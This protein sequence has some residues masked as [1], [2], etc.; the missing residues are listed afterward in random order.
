MAIEIT[1]LDD[2][3]EWNDL[4]DRSSQATPFH[5]AESLDVMARH[6]DAT[7][8]PYAGFKGH[9]PVGLF[10]IFEIS[11]GPVSTAFSPPPDLKI[12]Y[13]GPALLNHTKQKQR[14]QEKTNSR[15][16]SGCLERL[17]ETVDPKYI[18]LRT[19]VQYTDT[20]PLIWGGF[21]PTTRYTYV[22]DIDRSADD[23]LAAFSSDARSN[24]TNADD[25]DYEIG[26]GGERE[27]RRTINE[28]QAYHDDQD[29]GFH[30][31]PEFVVDL[32][33]ELPEDCFRIHTCRVDGELV[34]G[35]ITLEEGEAIYGWQSWGSRET[36]IPVNDLLDWEIITTARERGRSQYDLV[37]ANNER[38]SKYKAKFGPQLHTYQTMERG[39]PAMTLVSEIYKRIRS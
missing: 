36:D 15:F 9:E 28:L 34:G 18:H 2:T 19:S 38:I 29:V 7:L 39:T 22:V 8:H 26:R 4:V 21:E 35:H 30:I 17:A 23:L 3:A 20:R 24:I 32:F 11:K 27:I 31:T 13:L 1:T 12:S 14:R 5:R 25:A 37:G 10:P 33:E 6:A 16:I